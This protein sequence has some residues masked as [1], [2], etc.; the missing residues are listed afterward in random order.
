MDNWQGPTLWH[1]GVCSVLLCCGMDGRGVWGWVCAKLLYLCLTLCD[2]MDCSPPGFSI[3][4]ILQARIL[5]WVAIPFSRRSSWFRD[6]TQVSCTAGRSLPSEPPE[7]NWA[8]V[9]CHALLQGLFP[10][11]RDKTHISCGSCIVGGL[12]LS[13]QGMDTC[14]CTA[15]S[16]CC[17][18]ETIIT[19]H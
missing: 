14:R 19:K 5:E 18:P 1:K 17:A 10:W 9:D 8:G 13:H 7:E 15:G 2:P 4:R 16:L 6:R 3:H 12:E 11:L